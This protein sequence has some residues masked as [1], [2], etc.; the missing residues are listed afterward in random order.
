MG[1]VLRDVEIYRPYGNEFPADLLWDADADEALVSRWEQAELVR[2]AKIGERVLGM[3][4]MNRQDKIR[5]HL[6]GVVIAPSV[7]RQ[8]LG[9]WLVGHAI[10]VA[11]SKGGRH[12]LTPTATTR[13]FAH[14][15]FRPNV[16]TTEE[17]PNAGAPSHAPSNSAQAA[18]LC[19][20]LIPE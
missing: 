9:R 13:M 8:G 16:V 14:L 15:G 10:G 7:R 2:I 11:E 5:F 12:V 6:L 1:L 17:A 19:L 4:A 18:N 20:D 3:Y